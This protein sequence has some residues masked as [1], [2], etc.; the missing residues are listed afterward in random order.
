MSA[1]VTPLLRGE[2]VSVLQ[3]ATA[4][5]PRWIADQLKAPVKLVRDL[6]E[7]MRREGLVTT[8]VLRSGEVLWKLTDRSHSRWAALAGPSTPIPA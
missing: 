5:T 4:G 7:T 8:R 6:L 1:S 3:G 2:L